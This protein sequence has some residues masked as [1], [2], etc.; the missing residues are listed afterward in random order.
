MNDVRNKNI[1][2]SKDLQK[3][4]YSKENNIQEKKGDKKNGKN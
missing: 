3:C 2:I 1:P 4:F